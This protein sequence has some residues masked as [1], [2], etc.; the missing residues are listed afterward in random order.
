MNTPNHVN[1]I[2]TNARQGRAVSTR[3]RRKS[4]RVNVPVLIIAAGVL[5]FWVACGLIAACAR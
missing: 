1:P 3:N 5:A 2:I 4:G